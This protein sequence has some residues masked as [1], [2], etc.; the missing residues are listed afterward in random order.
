MRYAVLLS[1]GL[2]LTLSAG[3]S[4][5]DFSYCADLNGDGE[6]NLNDP[7]YM[8]EEHRGILTLPPDKGD[9]DFR[10]GYNMGD[11]RYLLS[12][13]FQG[14]P[15]G[16]C[17]PF[18]PYTLET[19]DDSLYFP[20]ATVLAGSGTIALSI[21]LVN[22]NPVS[23]ILIPFKLSDFPGTATVLSVEVG[24]DIPQAIAVGSNDD[25]SG[26]VIFSALLDEL[27]PG[28]HLL[29]NIEIAYNS[30][31]GGE[32]SL[33]TYVP[34][35]HTFLNYVYGELD[36]NNYADL[37]I[38]IPTIASIS[39]P[40]FPMMS[41]EP[42]TLFFETLVDYP[43]PEP[44][45][46]TVSSD[47]DQFL[48]WAATE[49]WISLDKEVGQS[50]ESVSV[51]PNI[52]ELSVGVHYGNIWINSSYALGSPKRIVVKLLLK[53]Q[54]PAFDANC[55]GIFNISDVVLQIQY[56]FGSGQIPCDPCT[57]EPLKK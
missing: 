15:E 9:L 3:A 20:A 53:S 49:D 26:V 7:I 33:E 19:G 44:Q 36:N 29:A 28:L 43:D 54:Y 46:F 30:A 6:I 21:V 2:L 31:G 14:Y 5:Q 50:G 18:P 27:E 13:L 37:T 34:R 11:L 48:W 51:T 55:D 56:M 12:Y 35:E 8:I 25:T 52:T 41:V 32:L 4:G 40:G 57:G 24:N 23:D 38:G 42:D 47:G 45:Q 1:L 22:Q 39:G 17:P 16:A 10:D